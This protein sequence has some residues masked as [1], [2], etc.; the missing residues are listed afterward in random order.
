MASTEPLPTPNPSFLRNMSATSLF[1]ALGIPGSYC[2]PPQVI[3]DC[4]YPSEYAERHIRGAINLP[5]SQVEDAA[6]LLNGYAAAPR[7]FVPNIPHLP[8]AKKALTRE[9]KIRE[10]YD[11][12]LAAA[13]PSEL[14]E[15]IY[16]FMWERFSKSYVGCYMPTSLIIY[17][18]ENSGEIGRRYAISLAILLRNSRRGVL[19]NLSKLDK[20]FE[21]F[22]RLFPFVCRSLNTKRIFSGPFLLYPTQILPYVYLGSE[23]NSLARKQ[24]EQLGIS[25]IINC[26]GETKKKLPMCA[27]FDLHLEACDDD[28]ETERAPALL[29][30]SECGTKF[31]AVVKYC[32]ACGVK[33]VDKTVGGSRRRVQ[34]PEEKRK[35]G[36]DLFRC[37]QGRNILIHCKTGNNLSAAVTIAFLM[38]IHRHLFRDSRINA[39]PLRFD[40]APAKA[41]PPSKR[42]AFTSTPPIN[43]PPRKVA[44]ERKM[45]HGG[46]NSHS[47]DFSHISSSTHQRPKIATETQKKLREQLGLRINSQAELKESRP[48]PSPS[49]SA[50]KGVYAN[51]SE[52]PWTLKRVLKFVRKHRPTTDI[53][54]TLLCDLARFE[55]TLI[56]EAQSDPSPPLHPAPLPSRKT[57]TN[58]TKP[59][60]PTKPPATHA[61]SHPHLQAQTAPIPLPVPLDQLGVQATGEKAVQGEAGRRPPTGDDKA[62]AN[63]G[64]L[65]ALTFWRNSVNA[66]RS[67]YSDIEVEVKRPPPSSRRPPRSILRKRHSTAAT[68]RPSTDE[69]RKSHPRRSHSVSF[70][71]LPANPPPNS[72]TLP[73]EATLFKL[74]HPIH[75]IENLQKRGLRKSIDA[76]DPSPRV[77]IPLPRVP[78]EPIPKAPSDPNPDQ[79]RDPNDPSNANGH[80]NRRRGSAS[81]V[82]SGQL[83]PSDPHPLPR[84][85][86]SASVPSS[87]MKSATLAFGSGAGAAAGAHPLM[88]WRK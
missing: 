37:V 65:R 55:S 69:K 75:R 64:V 30:C 61:I 21:T 4:R 41:S 3:I 20:G 16:N 25:Y 82:G 6:R 58:S 29:F 78:R 36:I 50:G 57:S 35:F 86:R 39:F 52:K 2:S 14:A 63:S 77:P 51:G 40:A 76:K 17:T 79:R 71:V 10:L 13:A 85:K 67:D 23:K 53:T 83:P 49:P 68:C 7:A 9:S 81:S 22:Y 74:P 8:P 72:P 56:L 66:N 62:S 38:Y 70:A 60:K 27:Y 88:Q 24:I 33:V 12:S 44:R 87:S 45:H 5:V 47:A 31:R 84:T 11:P 19:H 59:T 48:S 15:R 32:S 80:L 43:T 26:E 28:D 54:H 1:N 42:H 73:A 46:A 34:K 18:S